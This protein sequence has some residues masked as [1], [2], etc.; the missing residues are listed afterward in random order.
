MKKFLIILFIVSGIKVNG[1]SLYGKVFYK[2][3]PLE[4]EVK[5]N[6]EHI[7][8]L[9]NEMEKIAQNQQYILEFNSKISKFHKI[10]VLRVS[11]Y[12]EEKE[13]LLQKATSMLYATNFTYF[14]DKENTK[15]IIKKEDANLYFL[16]GKLDWVITTETKKIGD[17]LCYKATSEKKLKNNK[18]IEYNSPVVAWFA[19]A[20][21]Y[22]YGPQDFI[23][24][25]GLI[26]ELKFYKTVY[27]ATNIEVNTTSNKVIELPKGKMIDYKEYQKSFVGKI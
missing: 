7:K 17:Y 26:L 22:S 21:P 11:K 13:R 5:S 3:E 8:L 9:Y 15:L 10:D 6:K 19:P 16:D 1:Q 4:I 25:P 12:S 20:L 23:G 14:F 2:I 27:L 18:G 24:L